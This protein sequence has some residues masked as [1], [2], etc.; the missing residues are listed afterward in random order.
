MSKTAIAPSSL[1]EPFLPR[2]LSKADKRKVTILH[3]AIEVYADL[4]VEYVSSK[5]V[6]RRAKTS[7]A[8]VQYYFPQK[9]DLVLTSAQLVRR[10]FQQY[11]IEKMQHAGGDPKSLLE[12]YV[13]ASF[14]W[15]QEHPSHIRFW[16]FFM[17]LCH[18]HNELRKEHL[19]MTH[20]GVSRISDLLKA[21]QKAKLFST[22]LE[23]SFVAK[24]IQNQITGALFQ[25][26]TEAGANE[27]KKIEHATW[28]S[29]LAWLS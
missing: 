16:C 14:H 20:M 13:R 15:A 9:I 10:H 17:Y 25:I 4:G 2:E 18:A 24:C 29:C 6:A 21:G 5:D 27:S 12:A 1:Y 11:V 22:K 23:N 7:A 8:L 19:K 3:A 28:Q 26:Y